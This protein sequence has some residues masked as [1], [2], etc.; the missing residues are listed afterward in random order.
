MGFVSYDAWTGFK[1]FPDYAYIYYG[2]TE[3]VTRSYDR[4]NM[5]LKYS[6][7][8]NLDGYNNLYASYQRNS[9]GM[10]FP[11]VNYHSAINDRV[12]QLGIL[13]WDHDVTPNYSYYVKLYYHAW[14][15]DYTRMRLAADNF[16][17]QNYQ[18]PW[19]YQD[20]GFNFLN[21]I[22]TDSEHELLVG[23]EYQNIWGK[24]MVTIM[25]P[26]HKQIY[27]GF[28][29][30]RPH[31]SF[32]EDWKV[33]MGARY[34]Y[35]DNNDSFVW[36]LSS[37]VPILPENK[38]FFKTNLGTSFVLPNIAQLYSMSPGEIGNPDLVPMNVFT[39]EASL[40]STQKY[41]D[42][43]LEGFYRRVKNQ[44]RL[45][46][47]VYQNQV[48]ITIT[49]GFTLTANFRPVEGLT[50]TGSF[51]KNNF[52]RLTTGYA[53]EF[54]KLNVQWDGKIGDYKYGIGMFNSYT[55]KI[56]RTFSRVG[57]NDYGSYWL[58]DLKLYFM[59]TEKIRFTVSIQNLFD[60]FY[61]YTW[62]Q[63]P[64]A[65]DPNIYPTFGIPFN[66]IVGVSYNF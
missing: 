19:G 16:S 56:Y 27:A 17:Y 65:N 26:I 62:T 63:F 15:T 4:L 8:F 29:Q 37:L 31:F 10:D 9:G 44:I 38:L 12:E 6:K 14:W 57:T 30:F 28:F 13:K 22:R 7:Q 33:A 50:L 61:G 45:T 20:W 52:D 34:N 11:W 42:I 64:Q 60:K 18:A 35:M 48:G 46:G 55:G 47:G 66:L 53:Y 49:K 21:S 2:N 58:S 5:G 41:F 36:N 54:A 3:P 43:N 25:A 24:D 1:M 32:W 40:G 59:P 51:T 39:V 23:A